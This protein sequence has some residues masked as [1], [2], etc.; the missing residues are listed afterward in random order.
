[1]T[2][3]EI[4]RCFVGYASLPPDRSETIE[5]SLK[6]IRQTGLVAIKSWRDLDL[7]GRV[8]ISEVCREIRDSNLLIFD[9]TGLNPN[10]LFELGYGI[11]HQKKLWILLDRSVQRSR[12][13]DRF[14]LLTTVGYHACAS[15]HEIAKG[16]LDAAPFESL[17]STLLDDL[18]ALP[19]SPGKPGN[20]LY[21]KSAVETTASTWVTRDLSQGPHDMV[22]DDP[23][24]S[25]QPLA[26]YVR[27]V[28]EAAAVACHLLSTDHTDHFLHNAK[29]ALVAGLAHGFGKQLL[30]L[31]HDPYESPL[32]YRDILKR[33]KTADEAKRHAQAW[34][35]TLRSENESVVTAERQIRAELRAKGELKSIDIGEHIAEHES[36]SLG[37]Y[38]VKTSVFNEV[39]KGKH[40]IVV[41][42]KGAG[43]SA[44]LQILAAEVR[45]D[46]RSF[47]C[48]IRPIAYELEGLVQLL[49]RALPSAE[50]GFLLESLWKFLIYTELARTAKNDL[51]SRPAWYQP[52]VE[53]A[54]LLEFVS[55]HENLV[56]PEISIRLENAVGRLLDLETSSSQAAGR[57]K[58]S[59]LLHADVLSQLRAILGRILH[60]KESVFVL[61]DNL[62]KAWDNRADLEQLSDL[63]FALLSLGGRLTEDF[64]RDAAGKKS[65]N[66]SLIL[67]LRGDIHAAMVRFARER[68]KLPVQR[69]SWE[70][71]VVLLRVVEERF[72]R[73]G[74]FVAAGEDV[75]SKYFTS[76]VRGLRVTD[77]L[78]STVLPRPRDMIYLV[79]AALRVAVNRGHSKIEEADLLEGEKEYS[80]FALDSLLAENNG[81]I[82]DLEA[83]L[84]EFLGSGERIDDAS[85][86]KAWK[87]ES[88][89]GDPPLSLASTLFDL[90]FLGVETDRDSYSF[91]YNEEDRRKL[92]VQSRKV[93]ESRKSKNRRYKINRPFHSFLEIGGAPFSPA[94]GSQLTL[95]LPTT[96]D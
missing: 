18:L 13:F 32:D 84:Y 28:Q 77:Y 86:L 54:E 25:P 89:R 67:F 24:E 75:W 74:A 93:T 29:Q 40:T 33:H 53:E 60:E 92:E 12:D 26:W 80:H 48:E 61:I 82:Q 90:N 2:C 55:N 3:M 43:K 34:V 72:M 1:M 27:R 4:P 79:K 95:A 88:R 64:A 6:L 87:A 30:M 58:I 66:L 8:I 22:L 65:V 36:Q 81:Q 14:Q 47:V 19:D 15:S 73:S 78:V 50:R 49:R 9:L 20:L 10:V 76:H 71:K 83:F 21:L 5:D 91:M 94:S 46:R 35:A 69:V 11:A 16:F 31:A 52:S 62:D 59:E 63:L 51:A 39:L 41:G 17:D 57:T 42:R 56:M 96:T 37:E 44:M 45:M 85:I 68:D 23:K 7:S 70:D 38:F